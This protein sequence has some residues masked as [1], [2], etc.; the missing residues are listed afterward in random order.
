MRDYY[1]NNP[2]EFT[3]PEQ[4]GASHIL[5][6][7]DP[8]AT[9]KDKAAA[10]EEA[11]AVLKEL[12]NAG[13]F[14]ALAKAHS[15]DPGSK[16]QGGNL[17]MFRKGDMVPPFEK[18]A[19]ALEKDELSDIVETQYGYHIIKGGDHTESEVKPYSEVKDTLEDKLQQPKIRQ[20][21]QKEIE[22][23]REENE[24]AIMIP[25]PPADASEND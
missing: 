19:L 16:E 5:I 18:A 4:Y 25:E 3:T 13:D 6:K 14:A 23:L 15:D 12:K 17:G 7:V 9:D 21:V 22:R 20:A 2:K 11:E 24:V 1:E 10:K 8:D